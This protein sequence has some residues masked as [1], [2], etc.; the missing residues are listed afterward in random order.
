MPLPR[1]PQC[2]LLALVAG[3]SAFAHDPVEDFVSDVTT[4]AKPWTHLEFQNDP[5]NFQFAVLSDRTGGP[6]AG[7]WEDAVKKLNWMRP[8]FVLSVGDLIRGTSENADTNAAEWDGMM[9]ML[10][11]LKMPF[12]FLPGNHD[13]QMKWIE[14]RVQPEDMLAEWKARFGT[15]HYSFVYKNVLFI[16]LFSNDGKEQ[17][18]SDEQAAY[19]ESTLAEHPDVRWTFLLLH[20]PLWAYPHESNFDRIEKALKQQQRRYT[21]LAGH[22]HRYVHWDRKKTDYIILASTGGGSALRGPAFGEF[23]HMAWFTMTD[24]GPVMANLDLSGIYPKDVSKFESVEWV[25]YLTKSSAVGSQVF[26]QED[27]QGRVARSAVM[28]TWRNRSVLP[29]RVSAKFDHSHHVHPESGMIERVIPPGESAVV[30][31]NLK[32]VDAFTAAEGVLLRMQSTVELGEDG[33]TGLKMDSTT[34][35]PLVERPGQVLP[36]ESIAFVGSTRFAAPTVADDL[37]IRYTTDGSDP[38]VDSPRL[39]ESLTFSEATELRARAFSASGITGPVN[40]LQFQP[41]S[42]GPGLLAYYYEQ[43]RRIRRIS[44]M[45]D[46]GHEP[47]VFVGKTSGFDV[48]EITRAEEN[49]A[50]VF[51]G[52]FTVGDAGEYAFHVDSL[53]GA[54]LLID[55]KP[56]VDDARKHP[57]REVSGRVV[58]APGRHAIELQFFQTNQ[59][60][61]LGLEYTPPGGSRGP[62]PH[63]AISIDADAQPSWLTKK[64]K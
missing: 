61:F 11:P 56:V 59:D 15:T 17:Y 29:L 6:R 40:R 39:M 9:E 49:F 2:L 10:A 63:D 12:F 19:F 47:P 51:H 28:L 20:H 4:E 35:I 27:E 38:T 24:E 25:S 21:V 64:S 41:V 53:D 33:E 48:D 1:L 52:W 54:R 62:I 22:H 31:V 58:L 57:R 32:S 5:D 34:D 18:I 36:T 55:G 14:G 44:E 43:D 23:D 7:V 60:Y 30:E 46:F 8:E 3:S 13:I 16:A 26:L 45:P 50:V 37:I 42:T